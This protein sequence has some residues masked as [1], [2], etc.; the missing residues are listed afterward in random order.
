MIYFFVCL[1]LCGLLLAL[2]LLCIFALACLPLA[3]LFFYGIGA[4]RMASRAFDSIID[5]Q[6]PE[7]K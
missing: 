5:W 1:Q 4:W 3:C 6:L 7:R 2:C